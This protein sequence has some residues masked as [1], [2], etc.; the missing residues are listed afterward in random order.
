MQI[1]VTVLFVAKHG[2]Q[3]KIE[4]QGGKEKIKKNI[5]IR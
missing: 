1:F 3:K 4:W 2:F 5:G